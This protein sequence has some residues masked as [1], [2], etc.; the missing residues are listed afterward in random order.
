M[1]KHSIYGNQILSIILPR[2]VNNIVFFKPISLPTY[3]FEVM[4]TIVRFCYIDGNLCHIGE[5][6][7]IYD[8]KTRIQLPYK[9]QPKVF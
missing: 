6:N 8:T 9:L 4:Y 5:D 7:I 1:E 3:N 2:P